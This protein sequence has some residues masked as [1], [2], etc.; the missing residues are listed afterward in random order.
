MGD[1]EV[2]QVGWGQVVESLKGQEEYFEINALF[3]GEPVESGENGGDV[4]TGLGVSKGA[5]SR[6]LDRLESMEGMRGD[7]SEEG[8]AVVKK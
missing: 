4:F 6:V 8:V 7:A 2:R 5:S 3:D 1:K